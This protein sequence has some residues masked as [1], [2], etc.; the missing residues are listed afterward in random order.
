MKRVILI[1]LLL[2]PLVQAVGVTPTS[3]NL[4][5]RPNLQTEFQFNFFPT[6]ANADIEISLSGDLAQYGVLDKHLLINGGTVTVR[7]SLPRNLESGMHYINVVGS[8]RPLADSGI[9][10]VT[11]ITVPVR[12]FVPYEGK[13]IEAS[14]D[15]ANINVNEIGIIYVKVKNIGTEPISE[16]Y[17]KISIFNDGNELK[18]LET[19]KIFL[20]LEESKTLEARFLSEDL[21]QGSYKAVAKVIFD[22]KEENL[23]K[24]FLIGELLINILNYTE[25]LTEHEINKFSILMESKWNNKIENIFAEIKLLNNKREI[26][27]TRTQQIG[28]DPWER[29]EL[30]TFLDLTSVDAGEYDINIILDYANKKSDTLGKVKVIKRSLE[31][32]N[33]VVLLVVIIVIT[34]IVWY[35]LIKKKIG[36]PKKK[37]KNA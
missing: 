10:A 11:A 17:A 4:N 28:L 19:K 16:L 1:F 36:K 30:Q 33:I 23:E 25:V 5:F 32:S 27:S 7:I 24:G 6:N 31:I 34:S 22:G 37:R 3:A 9:S 26:I 2:I 35:L 18:K 20:N 21:R 15:V 12:I 8:E 14:L 13:H 29:K